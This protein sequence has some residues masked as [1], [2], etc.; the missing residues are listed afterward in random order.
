MAPDA[1]PDFN[2]SQL[3]LFRALTGDLAVRDAQDLMAYPFFSLAKSKRVTPIEF[4]SGDIRVQVEG[5]LEHGIA[6]IWDADVLI[7]TTSQIVQARDTGIAPS[8][9]LSA[10]PREILTF[11]RRGTSI[12]DYARLK[13][14]L[15]RLQST[16]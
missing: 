1:A 4:R 12:R 10:T 5:T 11:L 2:G 14:A 8:R 16:S 15:D 6:T 9:R 13:A 7:W 3:Q